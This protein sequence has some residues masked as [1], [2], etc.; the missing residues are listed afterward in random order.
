MKNKDKY[1][2]ESEARK[3]FVNYCVWKGVAILDVTV[4]RYIEWL[5]DDDVTGVDGVAI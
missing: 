3:A 4:S 2:I 1:S 5:F